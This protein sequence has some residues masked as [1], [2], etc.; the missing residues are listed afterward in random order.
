[1]PIRNPEIR[2]M[3]ESK[4]WLPLNSQEWSTQPKK[5]WQRNLQFAV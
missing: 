2:E 5:A 3:E 4:G 1:M